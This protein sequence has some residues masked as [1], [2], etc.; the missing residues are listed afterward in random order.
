[1]LKMRTNEEI[2]G[3]MQPNLDRI[4]AREDGDLRREP[5]EH[6]LL[7]LLLFFALLGHL[8]LDS[9]AV[10]SGGTPILFSR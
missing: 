4:R 9:I 8:V 1:M 3:I 6:F 10:R 7:A 2:R 5:G